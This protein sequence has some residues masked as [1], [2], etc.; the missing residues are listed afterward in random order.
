M[1]YLKGRAGYI[2]EQAHSSVGFCNIHPTSHTKLT[3]F[4]YDT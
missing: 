3:G 2:D 1:G 4:Q